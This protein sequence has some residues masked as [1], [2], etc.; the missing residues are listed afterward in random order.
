MMR[1]AYG[2][3]LFF[4]S[5]NYTDSKMVEI[6]QR[7]MQVAQAKELYERQ[8]RIVCLGLAFFD[9]DGLFYTL[10]PMHNA[11]CA[12]PNLPQYYK[13]SD[14]VPS[15]KNVLP[16]AELQVLLCEC[17]AADMLVHLV[18]SGSSLDVFIQCL[19]LVWNECSG[20]RR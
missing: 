1:Y 10:E 2:Q 7:P 13:D 11:P 3:R 14:Y 6:I 16:R 9:V 12:N 19:R 15:T 5:K 8:M 20:C 18:Q 17:G 4:S